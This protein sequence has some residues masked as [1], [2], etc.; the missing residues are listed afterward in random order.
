MTLM[1]DLA[2]DRC[3]GC[4]EQLPQHLLTGATVTTQFL[5]PYDYFAG[6]TNGC[7]LL[8]TKTVTT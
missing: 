1:S 3:S 4:N 2:L 6:T 5:A 7:P 8:T